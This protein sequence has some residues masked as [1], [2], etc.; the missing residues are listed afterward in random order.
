M[1]AATNDPEVVQ[2]ITAQ[3]SST[4]APNLAMALNRGSYGNDGGVRGEDSSG[5]HRPP[6]SPRLHSLP[7]NV[8]SPLGLLAEA[9]LQN[10]TDKKYSL[11]GRN[12]NAPIRPSPLSLGVGRNNAAGQRHATSDVR[13]GGDD[14]HEVG[15]AATDYFK[16][17]GIGVF[18]GNDD[19]VPE[20]L[21]MVSS[22]E[23]GELF[24]IYFKHMSPHVPLIYREFH[25]P[26]L[27]LQRSQFL[28]TVICALAARY[29]TKRPEL[30]SSLSAY[31][32][33]LSFEVPS[34]GYKSVE[35]CQAYLLLAMW[36]LG[37]EKTFEQDR[38]WLM[39][40]M[41]IR[42]ATDLNLHRKSV[43]SG[44]DTREGRERD[45]EII[46]RERCWLMCFVLDRSVSAQMGKPY[47]L[48]EDYIIRHANEDSWHKQRFS[49]L[50]DAGLAAYVVLQQIMS[51]AIDSIYSSTT[52]VSGLREDCDYM[53][54]V[55]SAHEELRR[56]IGHW[57][58]IMQ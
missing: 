24:D 19:R 35:V 11:A 26:E 7:D 41:A 4:T 46:N 39:L 38:T 27:V 54:I 10:T 23:I 30:H 57:T 36:T 28:C 22:D 47:T 52:T 50:S 6:L 33:R 31:A 45:L 9:S 15:V 2:L 51:R 3:V 44:L 56:W 42:M 16:P 37:P 25:T 5:S 58:H 29:Y 20:L 55:R 14:G 21:T 8:L 18:T 43:A 32:K 48:R 40:G 49:L 12:G 17:G 53:L 1:H 34:R 13:G